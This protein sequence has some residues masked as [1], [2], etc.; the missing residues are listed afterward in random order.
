[1]VGVKGLKPST[2]RSQTERAINCATPRRRNPPFSSFTNKFV[3]L[4]LLAVPP[5]KLSNIRCPANWFKSSV[6]QQDYCR[7]FEI[8]PDI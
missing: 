7:T 3:N 5:L 8:I 6:K 4:T 2:S 1:M